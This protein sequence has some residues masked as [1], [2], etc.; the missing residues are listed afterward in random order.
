[1]YA[2]LGATPIPWVPKGSPALPGVSTTLLDTI[3][4]YV[5]GVGLVIA[6]FAF[7][8]ACILIILQK[9]GHDF[10][11]GA[12]SRLPYI[13]GGTVALSLAPTVI[14]KIAS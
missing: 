1:M 12:L 13:L 11:D 2:I 14:S 7:A 3:W 4:S 8:I 9:S 5:Q 6:F 10:G